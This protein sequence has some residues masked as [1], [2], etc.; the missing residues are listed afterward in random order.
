MRHRHPAVA[1]LIL[2]LA[3]CNGEEPVSG[4]PK[5]PAKSPAA[6][7]TSESPEKGETNLA[8]QL[9]GTSWLIGQ[10][11]PAR[12]VLRSD[13]TTSSSKIKRA[14]GAQWDV[15]DDRTIILSSKAGI[16]FIWM[17]LD[18]DLKRADVEWKSGVKTTARR[19]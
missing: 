1:T 10:K 6:A 15:R 16:P 9:G 7:V 5:E 2:A 14:K 12:I 11:N 4:S 19:E 3:A 13:G 8:E 18:E 17:T